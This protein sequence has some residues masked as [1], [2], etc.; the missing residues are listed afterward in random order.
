MVALC[1][2]DGNIYGARPSTASKTLTVRG[3]RRIRIRLQSDICAAI[4]SQVQNVTPHYPDL[5]LDISDYVAELR[6][7][8]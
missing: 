2:R 7:A 4:M 1:W 6:D 5:M 3:K 8:A